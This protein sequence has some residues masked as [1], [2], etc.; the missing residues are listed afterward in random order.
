MSLFPPFIFLLKI[1][2]RWHSQCKPRG[3][4][5][6]EGSYKRTVTSGSVS[7][8]LSHRYSKAQAVSNSNRTLHDKW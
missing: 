1:M 7:Y 3:R 6:I 5:V 2:L 8:V 4:P